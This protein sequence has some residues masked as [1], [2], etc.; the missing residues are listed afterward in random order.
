MVRD[1]RITF[2]QGFAN[3]LLE[4]LN[5]LGEFGTRLDSALVEVV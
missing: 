5:T 4:A 3:L 2:L 1:D